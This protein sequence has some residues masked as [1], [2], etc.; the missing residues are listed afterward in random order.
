MKI[1]SVIIPNYNHALYLEKRVESVL[2][3][4]FQDFEIIIIDDCSTDSS[5]DVINKYQEHEKIAHI[6]FNDSNSGTPFGLWNYAIEKAQGKY[7]WIAESDDWSENNFLSELVPVLENSNAV[8]AHSNS[9]FFNHGELK[10]N[11][12]WNSFESDRWNSNYIEEGVN[13]L[14]EYGRFKCPVINVSSALI[15]KD[16]LKDEF[17]PLSYRYSGDWWFWGN[18]FMSGKVAFVAKPLNIIRVHNLS[19]TQ[20]KKAINI[21]KLE[22]D[23]R[24]IND[25]SKLLNIRLVYSEKYKWI[26]DFWLSIFNYKGK[27]LSAEHHNVDLPYSFKIVFYRRFFSFLFRKFLKKIKK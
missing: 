19:V 6:Y 27:Y 18:I 12:W 4:S 23:I 15:R 21:N 17:Y 26:I 25:L 3:Q 11:N 20:N 1:V 8:M 22:E 24:V 10:P 9:L 2:N 14:K 5:K 7:I 13:L 16:I